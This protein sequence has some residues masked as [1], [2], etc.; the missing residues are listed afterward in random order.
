MYGSFPNLL[1]FSLIS[2][3]FTEAVTVLFA[4]RFPTSGSIRGSIIGGHAVVTQ[5]DPTLLIGEGSCTDSNACNFG[6][7]GAIKHNSCNGLGAC[8]AAKH[9]IVDHTSCNG[10]NACFGI[11]SSF[12]SSTSCQAKEA[13]DNA[14]YAHIGVNSCNGENA[15]AAL[16]HSSIGN[17]SCNSE[18]ICQSCAGIVPDNACN[19]PEGNDIIHGLCMYC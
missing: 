12:I 9:V 6:S 1:I 18:H 16:S 8:Q 11:E 2:V 5:I 15:C 7:S 14:K 10:E 3:F 19:D 17:N 13:C 4:E